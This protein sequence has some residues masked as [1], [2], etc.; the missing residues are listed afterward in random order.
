MIFISSQGSLLS[1]SILSWTSQWASPRLLQ[2]LVYLSVRSYSGYDLFLCILTGL[3]LHHDM[4][5]FITF[6]IL[7]FPEEEFSSLADASQLT[8]LLSLCRIRSSQSQFLVCLLAKR[9]LM[10]RSFLRCESKILIH[11]HRELF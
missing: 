6:W 11:K 1:L 8:S 9:T 5:P 10:R 4:M 3:H 7:S 2:K